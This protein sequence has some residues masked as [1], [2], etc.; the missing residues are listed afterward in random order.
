MF[1]ANGVAFC[2]WLISYGLRLAALT[3]LDSQEVKDAFGDVVNCALARGKAHAIEELCESKLLEVPNV[4]VPGYNAGAY[5]ELKAA[6]ERL[7]LLEL[8]HIAMMERDQDYPINVIMQGLTLAKHIGE[9]AEELPDYFLKL[10]SSQLQVPIFVTPRD[11]LDPFALEKE[12]PLQEALDAHVTRVEKKKGF[13][14]KAILCCIG[15]AHLSRS[16]GVPVSVATVAPK[17][18][19]LLKRL[20]EA[21]NAARQ[22]SSS[23]LRRTQSL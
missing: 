15:A 18:A 17:D 6:M 16:D 12:I 10:D 5:G 14:A 23:G 19:D 13:K 9:G 8:P 11:I 1:Q 7:K 4:Q 2:R 3:T 20:S 22:A 21:G